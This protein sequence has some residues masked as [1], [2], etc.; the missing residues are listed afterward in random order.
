[1]NVKLRFKHEKIIMDYNQRRFQAGK[2]NSFS[3]A[4][5]QQGI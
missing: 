4:G 1:M 2:T 5:L 3:R